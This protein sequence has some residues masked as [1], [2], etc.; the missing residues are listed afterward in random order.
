MRKPIF[1]LITVGVFIGLQVGC[2]VKGDPV[3]PGKPAEIGRGE[4]TFR[5]AVEDL[6][7]EEDENTYKR[8]RIKS[9]ND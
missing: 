6:K 9:T 3:P 8:K 5:R 2:G 4:P 1:L 7:L